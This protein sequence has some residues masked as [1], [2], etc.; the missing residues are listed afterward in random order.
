M[1]QS[2]LSQAVQTA[3][4]ES[5]TVESR[6]EFEL[7]YI[8]SRTRLCGVTW[9]LDFIESTPF[10]SP[11]SG[12]GV[13]RFLVLRKIAD[14]GTHNVAKG[15]EGALH[16]IAPL[17]RPSPLSSRFQ[18]ITPFIANPCFPKAS[19]P[20]TVSPQPPRTTLALTVV[21]IPDRPQPCGPT[22]S[23]S[24]FALTACPV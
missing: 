12:C 22:A 23:A 6:I 11:I 10:G 5:T 13:G 7:T 16:F 14:E 3:S 9:N 15:L 2:L 24:T 4:D 19:S 8:R 21:F 1:L 20:A 17:S 18:W